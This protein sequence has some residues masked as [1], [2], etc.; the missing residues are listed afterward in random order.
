[1]ESEIEI[2]IG[3]LSS[4]NSLHKY[5][6]KKL[7]SLRQLYLDGYSPQ[8]KWDANQLRYGKVSMAGLTAFLSV[9]Y[10][11]S[12]FIGKPQKIEFIWQPDLLGFL[13]DISFIEI[14]KK[15]NIFIFES[16]RIGGIPHNKT[17]PNTKIIYYSDILDED[18][19]GDELKEYKDYLKTKIRPNFNI[20]CSEIFK[21]INNDKLEN[22]V[23]KTAVELIV[24]GLVHGKSLVFVGLQRT[25]KRI[26]VAV[27]DSGM[28][29]PKSLKNNFNKIDNTS[30]LSH[31]IAL[32][33]GCIIQTK[34]HGIRL[35]LNEVL[36][37]K[38]ILYKDI[39]SNDGW[40]IAS[41]F[42]T[43]IRWQK[44]NWKRV[45]E[46]IDD[47]YIVESAN[48]IDVLLGEPVD[49]YINNDDRKTGYW[50]HFDYPIK[51]SRF[52]FEIPLKK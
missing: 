5:I 33:L 50:Q 22:I 21:Y 38:S 41:S 9:A 26:T 51:G 15:L 36:D 39:F 20:R 52:V 14:S 12:S 19:I 43:E 2:N 1:M 17:N 49:F 28:G 46:N 13:K 34:E 16:E 27:C 37:M 42:N 8:V 35:A 29:F 44:Y 25:S 32:L 45:L 6:G 48:N 31:P 30:L 7:A 47:N 3:P 23:S 11:V 4:I 24:N 40:M 10:G 18:L